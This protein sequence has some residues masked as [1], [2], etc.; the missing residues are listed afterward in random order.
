MK[1]THYSK[2]KGLDIPGIN[3]GD[4]MEGLLRLLRLCHIHD[5]GPIW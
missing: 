3:L 4:L 1:F 5:S 2:F